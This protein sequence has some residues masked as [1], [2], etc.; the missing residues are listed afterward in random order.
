M[1]TDVWFVARLESAMETSGQDRFDFGEEFAGVYVSGIEP[2][3]I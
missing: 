3:E 2:V 1:P